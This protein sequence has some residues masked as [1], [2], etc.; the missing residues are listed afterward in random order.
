MDIIEFFDEHDIEYWK[1]GKNVSQGW[2]NIQCPFCGDDS[3]HLGIRLK[4]LTCHCWKCGKK[5]LIKIISEVLNT[6]YKE[7][8]EL[9]KEIEGSKVVLNVDPI[10]LRRLGRTKHL[11]LMPDDASIH[12]P[13]LHREYLRGRG[14]PPFRI[15]RQYKL[16]AVYNSGK[17]C[18]RIII[19]I[20]KNGELKSFTSRDVTGYGE[21][22]YLHASPSESAVKAKD[23]IY[24]LDSVNEGGDA[25]LVE[26]VIDVWKLGDGAISTFG[27]N[28]SGKQYVE[29]ANKN[30]R[31]LFL[32][33]DAD[34]PGK[35][36]AIKTSKIVAPIVDSVE[37][38][39]L[40]SEKNDPGALSIEEAEIAMRELGLK[41]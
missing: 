34:K 37:I 7:A 39:K 6:S 17:Y 4:D 35:I 32:L 5:N 14:F 9:S 13:K 22:K 16:K 21:P 3:N 26:G 29:L 8:R 15:I 40:D 23:L 10:D 31:T 36:A 24:N 38:V 11:V 2:I 41:H 20:F 19:P 18:F 30:I 28:V 27:T 33:F 12:F 1:G 25:V